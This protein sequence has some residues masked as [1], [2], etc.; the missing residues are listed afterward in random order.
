MRTIDGRACVVTLELHRNLGSMQRRSMTVI[1]SDTELHELLKQM[2]IETE[3]YKQPFKASEQVQPA[4]IDLRLDKTF[5][6][7]RRQKFVKELDLRKESIRQI[8]VDRLFRQRTFRVGECV[9]LD[10]GKLL[11][12]RTLETFTIPNGYVGKLEGRSS[13]SRLGIG[14]HCT[15]DFINPG[16]RGKMPLQIVNHGR[17]PVRLFAFLPICQL[18]VFKMSQPAK[19]PYGSDGLG[20]KYMND[21]GGPSRFWQDERITKLQEACG[22]INIPEKARKTMVRALQGKS[23]EILE[24]FLAFLHH[25]P[26]KDF[27]STND[28]LQRFA[29]K[30]ESRRTW[31]L[32]R[33]YFRKWL[34]PAMTAGS[35]AAAFAPPYKELQWA[36]WYTNAIFLLLAVWGWFGADPPGQVFTKEDIPEDTG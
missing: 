33:D 14:I 5:W 21:E 6:F 13:F 11:L 24:R 17:V 7:P 4:S 1:L 36:Y 10:P 28:I 8:E 12:G 29:T 25:L 19:K 22:R 3:E 20:S 30:E 32:F 35:I 31:E 23:P 16:W 34:G 15:G 2:Q 18:L 26:Q 9:T 27:T